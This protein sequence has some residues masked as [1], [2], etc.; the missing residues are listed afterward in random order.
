MFGVTARNVKTA[1]FQECLLA[2]SE[3][4]LYIVTWDVRE[5]RFAPSVSLAF[6]SVEVAGMYQRGLDRQIQFTTSTGVVA[7]TLLHDSDNRIDQAKN[8]TL[9]SFLT[10]RGVST[11]DVPQKVGYEQDGPVYF[12]I[13]IRR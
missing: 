2:H 3:S 13:F 7:I 1:K 6:A 9:M 11:R 4:T 12:P 8:E 5:Q 10:K